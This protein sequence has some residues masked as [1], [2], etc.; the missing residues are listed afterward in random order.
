MRQF[1]DFS[2]GV[3][4]N[5]LPGCVGIAVG[6]GAIFGVPE[7]FSGVVFS[8]FCGGADS[9]TILL[10][11]RLSGVEGGGVKTMF[12]LKVSGCISATM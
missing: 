1:I 2:G 6:F 5:S 8:N 3:L 9:G 4:E 10:R 12:T 11:A 7:L